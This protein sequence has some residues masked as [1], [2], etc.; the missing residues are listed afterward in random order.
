MPEMGE[1]VIEATVI[2]WLV[3]EGDTVELYQPL[4][5]VN[6]DKVDSEVPSAAAGTVLK[7]LAA[8]EQVVPVGQALCWVGQPGEEIPADGGGDAA[9]APPPKAEKPAPQ[10]AAEPQPRS[11]SVPAPAAPA[12][13]PASNG[14]A[15]GGYASPLVARMAAQMKVDLR[16]VPGTGMGGRITREDLQNYIRGG[17]RGGPATAMAA[18]PATTPAPAKGARASFISPAVARLAGEHALDLARITGTGLEGRITKKDIERVVAAGGVDPLGAPVAPAAAQAMP[19][20]TVGPA[21]GQ[22]LPGTLM[23]LDTMRKS[24]AKHMVESKHTSP[25]VT[26]I[27]EAD[28]SAVARHRAQNKD[29]FARDGANLTFTAYFVAAVVAGLK[30]YP[31][32]NSSWT[33]EGIAIHGD[34]NIGMAAALEGGGLIVP[35]IKQA[36]GL[37]L[38]GIARAVNDLAERARAK[39]LTPDE[40]RGG[41]FTITNHGT[42][43][44][45]FATPII[46]Q[47]QCGILGV[48]MIQKRAVVINDAIAIRPMVYMGLTFDHRMLDGAV[49]DYFLGTVKKALEEWA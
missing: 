37:S 46:N 11:T 43:G 28:L 21:A 18:Q 33:E 24:I 41:T 13:R 5:E 38:L 14:G 47:P 45:L 10:P 17:G 32:L 31:I 49:A 30:A 22:P 48:G 3:K 39:K 26:T 8:P 36:D 12:P 29:L 19:T 40:V 1:G 25:H 2:R 20:P 6:T 23:K 34:I 16:N 35:V 15:G 27:M 4:V 44:S 42:S 7:I 9:P